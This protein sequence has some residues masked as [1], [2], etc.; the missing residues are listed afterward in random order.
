M[1]TE[2]TTYSTLRLNQILREL[3][4]IKHKAYRNRR[5]KK[6]ETE[7]HLI[8]NEL[9]KRNEVKRYDKNRTE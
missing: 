8:K 7:I 9:R 1:L 3:C 2:L 6:I 5:I 4:Q